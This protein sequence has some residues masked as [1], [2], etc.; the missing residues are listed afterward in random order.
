MLILLISILLLITSFSSFC[1]GFQILTLNRVVSNTPISIVET[2]IVQDPYIEEQNFLF[3]KNEFEKRIN[4]YY[5]FELK[6]FKDKYSLD[7]YYFNEEDLS[8]CMEDDCPAVWIKFNATLF[9]NYQYE[10]NLIFRIVYHF[11]EI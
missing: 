11:Y 6:S 8:I 7:F 10:R 1:L 2:S 9:H 5:D 3:S 4:D